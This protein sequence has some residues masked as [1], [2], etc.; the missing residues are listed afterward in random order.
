MSGG[1]IYEQMV[2]R[3]LKQRYQ[4]VEE[5]LPRAATWL[6]AGALAPWEWSR[7]QF[8][9][10]DYDVSVSAFDGM[11][12]PTRPRCPTIVIVHHLD[13]SQSR[14]ADLYRIAMP[15]TE[16]QLK[17]AAKVVAVSK[18]WQRRLM[19]SGVQDTAV[20]PNAFETEAFDVTD[21]EVG[22]L[23]QHYG[24]QHKPII[25][26]GT[27]GPGKG[28]ESAFEALK[29]LDAHFVCSGGSSPL[30]DGPRHLVLPYRD[31]LTL[32][33]ASTVVV[34]M[35]QFEEG[36]C[37]LSHEAMLCGTPVVGS[38]R[39]GMRELLE[40]G[41]Q[42]ICP[43]FSVLRHPV[44]EMLA[45]PDRLAEVGAA[46]QAFARLFDRQRF[47]ESWVEVVQAVANVGERP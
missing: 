20:I 8:S 12:M 30:V 10:P 37:R 42:K 34:T 5:P 1:N 7:K 6:K 14:L 38:G 29:H 27:P 21:D 13:Y 4:V 31:Y 25:H 24:L 23:K 46:G 36:W 17:S 18:F 28:V 41:G 39:G 15:W 35:S 19:E 32:L 40:G 16:R 11:F 26:L 44:S 43:A 45:N 2:L 47:D 22:A 9:S 3:A 33:K